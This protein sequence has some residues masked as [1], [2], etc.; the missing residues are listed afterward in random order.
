M[1]TKI[2]PTDPDADFKMLNAPDQWPLGHMV[3]LTNAERRTHETEGLTQGLGIVFAIPGVPRWRVY[4]L[5]ILDRRARLA[6]FEPTLLE[7]APF[8]DYADAAEVVS[9]GWRV[10]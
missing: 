7:D 1:T 6:H 10:D 3:A 8:E 4:R 2:S 5:N 9:A